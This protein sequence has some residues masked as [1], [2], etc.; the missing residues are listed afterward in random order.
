VALSAAGCGVVVDEDTFQDRFPEEMC[1]RAISCLWDDVPQ[2][3]ETCVEQRDAVLDSLALQCD[4]YDGGAAGECLRD[5][6]AL[7]CE[8]TEYRLPDALPGQCAFV[9]VCPDTTPTFY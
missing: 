9:Y 2:D 7:S 4:L 6:R 8:S 1:S 3:L 5:L